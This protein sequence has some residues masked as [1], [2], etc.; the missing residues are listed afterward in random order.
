MKFFKKRALEKRFRLYLK[1][2]AYLLALISL[3]CLIYELLVLELPVEHPHPK[4]TFN[5][6]ILFALFGAVS[7]LCFSKARK[8]K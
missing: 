3:S 1:I 7:C 6:F 5:F 4:D 8:K 2:I